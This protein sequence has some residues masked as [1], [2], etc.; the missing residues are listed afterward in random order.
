MRPN[1]RYLL[2]LWLPA[3]V[4]VALVTFQLAG[5]LLAGKIWL[6]VPPLIVAIGA[7][8]LIRWR[9]RRRIHHLLRSESP[10][11]LVAFYRAT[12]KRGI[13]PDLDV[14]AANCYSQVYILYADYEAARALLQ[15]IEWEQRSPYIRAIKLCI[16]VQ[17]CYLATHE[18]LQGLNL[19][20]TAQ[21][22]ALF[23]G[24]FPGARST[25][26][27]FESY[28]EI[29]EVLCGQATRTTIES[30]ERKFTGTG[31]PLPSQLFIAWGLS[32][33]Y[34]KTGDDAKA[35]AMR[36]YIRET[37]PHCRALTPPPE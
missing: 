29:G 18:Y 17:L 31:T 6:A 37:A 9:I 30:L 22:M 34:A 1:T 15:N 16:E 19:A 21:E 24:I 26:S 4:L 36:S 8:V 13:G 3:I 20:R 25:A 28:V 5:S 33:A 35:Q 12:F 23:P 32:V 11:D 7:L 14:L 10:A 27:A 2:A